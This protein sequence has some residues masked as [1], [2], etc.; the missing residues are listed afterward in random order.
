M[1]APR[2][3][4]IDPEGEITLTLTSQITYEELVSQ[5]GSVEFSLTAAVVDGSTSLRMRVSKKHLSFASPVFKAMLEGQFQE[6]QSLQ[7]ATGS[8]EVM[9]H[10][11]NPVALYMLLLI[12]HC[13]TRVLPLTIG[14]RTL[15]EL[16]ILIDKYELHDA[17][18]PFTTAWYGK[19][20]QK[21]GKSFETCPENR[22][23][24]WICVTLILGN[25]VDFRAL[26][27][28]IIKRSRQ[29]LLPTEQLPIQ[30]KILGRFSQ[31][32]YLKVFIST[33]TVDF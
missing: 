1:S 4:E 24:G 26:T 18:E 31:A 22:F 28:V 29:E 25:S 10:D 15:T 30:Q 20:V 3:L 32:A 17:A 14:F 21:E 27:K 11:D 7:T 12:I 8:M 23:L 16:V 13:K 19:A 9:L 6:G 2:I 5:A 33:L